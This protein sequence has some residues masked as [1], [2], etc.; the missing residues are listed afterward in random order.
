MLDLELVDA[1]RAAARVPEADLD[2][3]GGVGDVPQHQAARDRRGR[4]RRC[5]SGCRP[6]RSSAG[7]ARTRPRRR[8]HPR[9][10]CR[11]GSG[12]CLHPPDSPGRGRRRWRCH[13]PG[14]P[15]RSGRCPS[16]SR[17]TPVPDVG[18][19]VM[20]PYVGVEASTAEVVLADDLDVPGGAPLVAGTEHGAVPDEREDRAEDHRPEADRSRGAHG[21]LLP[22]APDPTPGRGFAAC[23]IGL[24]SYRT[25]RAPALTAYMA[26]SARR[27]VSGSVSASRWVAAPSE[28]R[29]PHSAS[30]AAAPARTRST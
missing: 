5:T 3:D 27:T 25:W 15:G 12:S 24:S 8:R 14:A 17:G 22:D 29:R 16:P 11:E 4:A 1:A 13:C 28:I 18:E 21:L 2:R 20:D 19:A 9:R 10:S 23:Q 7:E 30:R 6:P 26:A